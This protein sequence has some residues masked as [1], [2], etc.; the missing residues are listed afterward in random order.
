MVW[1]WRFHVGRANGNTV[2]NLNNLRNF[3]VRS[4][5]NARLYIHRPHI[6]DYPDIITGKNLERK[7]P[8]YLEAS[9]KLIRNLGELSK[10]TSG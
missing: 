10:S 9:E 5:R 7:K 8:H 1:I 2:N 4:S 3:K 6:A